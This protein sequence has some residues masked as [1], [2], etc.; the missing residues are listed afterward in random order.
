MKGSQAIDRMRQVIRLQHKSLATED[1][2]VFWLRRYI[3]ARHTISAELSSEKKLER[4]LTQLALHDNL[5]ASTQNQAFNAVVFFY[6]AVLGQPLGNV[7]ALRAKRTVS[8]RSQQIQNRK[9]PRSL[10]QR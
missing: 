2:C 4:F 7:D 10:H 9:F 1:C 3:A 8:N 5:A 6:K